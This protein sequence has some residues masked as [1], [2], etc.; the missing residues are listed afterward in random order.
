M[1]K[2]IFGFLLTLSLFGCS[3]DSVHRSAEKLDDDSLDHKMFLN[4]TESL[5][6]CEETKTV[7]EVVQHWR[8]QKAT[9]NCQGENN[10]FVDMH[11]LIDGSDTILHKLL[12]V[13]MLGLM[14]A[15]IVFAIKNR[16]TGTKILSLNTVGLFSGFLI[17]LVMRYNI[18]LIFAFFLIAGWML[19]TGFMKDSDNIKQFQDKAVEL[20]SLT[21]KNKFSKDLFDYLLCKNSTGF[22]TSENP[23]LFIVKTGNGYKIQAQYKYCE[24]DG[25]FGIDTAG[26]EIAKKN[27]FFDYEKMQET[28]I[29]SELQKLVGRIDL[30][31][32]RAAIAQNT[33]DVVRVPQIL[34]CENTPVSYSGL[35][36]E[37]KYNVIWKDLECAS[38][39]FVLALNKTSGMTEERLETLATLTGSK[40]IHICDGEFVQQAMTDKAGMLQKYKSCINTSCGGDASLYACSVALGKYNRIDEKVN[41]DFLTTSTFSIYDEEPEIR[42]AKMFMGTLQGRTIFNKE[43]IP[44]TVDRNPIATLP[45]SIASDSRMSFQKV[46]DLLTAFDIIAKEQSV[47]E[48]SVS[49]FLSKQID[50]GDDGFIGTT[51][52]FSCLSNPFGIFK[53]KYDCGGYIYESKL[54]ANKF[55]ALWGQITLAKTLLTPKSGRGKLDKT[56]PAYT[57]ASEGMKYAGIPKTALAALLPFMFDEVGGLLFEDVYQENYSSIMGQKGE[58]YAAMGCIMSSKTCAD[59]L[60]SAADALMIGMIIFGWIIPLTPLFIMTGLIAKY[61]SKSFIKPMLMIIR[62]IVKFG[63]NDQRPD[64][65]KNEVVIECENLILNP[66][67]ISVGYILS[68]ILFGVIAIFFIGDIVEFTRSVIEITNGDAGY[69]GEILTIIFSLIYIYLFYMISMMS[70]VAYVAS[71][72]RSDGNVTTSDGKIQSA[73]DLRRYRKATTGRGLE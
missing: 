11:P 73:A 9:Y 69:L 23:N 15:Y 52:Y 56:D 12:S 16:S 3:G 44:F 5:F 20:P 6:G 49:D 4:I 48:F 50:P 43:P 35:S 54:I 60:D 29:I 55:E 13:C 40:K 22:V 18:R 17:H 58:Y 38:K 28:E 67:T 41:L 8:V 39:P 66:L 63:Q 45:V 24:F 70:W 34:T 26:I 32:K 31:A 65:D 68:Q 21:V 19:A 61:Y 36:N 59:V 51:R 25:S 33:L 62:F 53:D 64:L 47:A 14:A 42:S 37:D 30:I 27:S 71:V 72:E 7:V 2:L 57:A 1:K 46:G 10:T